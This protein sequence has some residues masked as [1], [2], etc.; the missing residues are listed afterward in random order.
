MGPHQLG[1]SYCSEFSRGFRCSKSLES[2]P[3]I[4]SA[5]QKSKAEQTEIMSFLEKC[6]FSARTVNADCTSS[7]GQACWEAEGC[8]LPSQ[9]RAGSYARLPQGVSGELDATT[10]HGQY[11]CRGRSLSTA[12]LLPH[13]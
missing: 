6:L 12:L 5:V 11:N 7:A 10:G 1:R 9:A 13:I 3:A 2:Q 8:P 4:V